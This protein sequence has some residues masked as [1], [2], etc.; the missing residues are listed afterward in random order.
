VDTPFSDSGVSQ[1][2][3][4]WWR[5]FDD[6]QLNRLIDTAF[7]ENPSLTAV[8]ERLQANEALAR[9]GR[10]ALFPQLDGTAGALSERED[11]DSTDLFSAGL[12]ASYE[13]DLWGRIRSEAEAERLRAKATKADYEAAALTLS[14]EVA[15]SWYRLLARTEILALIRE[16]IAA[17]EKVAESLL[18]RFRGG[19]ARS[20]DVLRQ[21]QLVEATRELKLIAEADIAVLKNQLQVLLGDAPQQS[22]QAT[23]SELPSLPPLP[24]TGLPAEL[25]LRRPDLQSSYLELLAADRDLASA[26]S[27]RFPRIDLTANLRSAAEDGSELFDDWLRSVAGEVVAPIVDGGSRR[28]EIERQAAIKRQ[29]LAE[30]QQASLNAYREVEDALVQERQEALRTESLNKQVDLQQTAFQQ[31]QKEFLNGV[32]NFIDVL[33]AQT[34]AQQLQRD[35]IES[36][37]RQIEFRIALHR[38]VAGSVQAY[39]QRQQP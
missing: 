27:E 37:R 31:L 5:A 28:A 21:E 12:S 1:R 39:E 14:G 23:T 32:G 9:R 26:I 3:N 16:Q 19:E 4:Q 10:S 36:M 30:F 25:L 38:S 29:R 24:E 13:V 7:A 18:T 15:L 34:G 2:Q 6:P 17:N 11:S 35:R 20:V 33:S 22:F 8:W